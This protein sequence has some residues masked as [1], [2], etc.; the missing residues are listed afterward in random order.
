LSRS[1]FEDLPA[2]GRDAVSTYLNE[3]KS[4]DI[5]IGIL[6]NSYGQKNENGISA[7]E[8]EYHTFLENVNDGEILLFIKGHDDSLRDSATNEFFNK[9][10]KI[11]SLQTIQ[12]N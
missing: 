2:G 9:A 8:L 5:Y 3:V 4:S 7:T 12:F 1:L 10:K 6:G 11:V